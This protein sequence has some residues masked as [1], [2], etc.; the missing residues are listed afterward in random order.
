MVRSLAPLVVLILVMVWL[1]SPSD[2]DPVR[3]I[4]PGPDLVY[5]ASIADFEVLAARNL[6]AGWRPT[7][8][9]VDPAT[10]NGPVGI[11][12]GYVSP[13]QEF[14]QVVHSS[15]PQ[16]QLL[17]G[18]LGEGY[19]EGG[20]ISVGGFGWRELLTADGE[21]ALVR[22]TDGSTVIVTGSATEAD[23]RLLAAALRPAGG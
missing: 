20:D 3:E 2:S 11:T 7:S 19:A 18:V 12:V 10:D 8:A 14:A 15:V 23:L 16:E 1:S 17:T 22:S 13:S 21:Q 5:A 9:R 4:D 6:P